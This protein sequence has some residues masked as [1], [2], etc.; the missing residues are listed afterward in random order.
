MGQH[1]VVYEQPLNERIRTCLRLEHLF[2]LVAARVSAPTEWD[3]RAAIDALIDINDLLS[4][5]DAKTELI[6]ELQRLSV[7][8]EGLKQSPDVD[9]GRLVEWL[10][11]S[12]QLASY[13][14]DSRCMPGQALRQ[15]ELLV[16]I[17]NR[18]AIP[19]GSCR[20]DLPAYHFWLNTS[21]SER[22]AKINFWLE[23]LGAIRDSIDL[24]LRTLREAAQI[25]QEIAV[26]G[27]YQQ[28]LNPEHDCKLVRIIPN[29][30]K[31]FPEVSGGRHRFSVRFLEQPDTR[32]RA[33]QTSDDVE[34]E[35]HRC[36]L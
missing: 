19:G 22:S 15:D 25:N 14:K 8:L 34:F 6:K 32:T 20:F 12:D 35:L 10:R 28:V 1:R 18:R 21:P 2:C 17:Q 16:S 4:R 31:Y 24:I 30:Q 23:D 33:G 11:E 26:G 9:P 36:L 7:R 3:S 13:L 5:S 27:F 29:G